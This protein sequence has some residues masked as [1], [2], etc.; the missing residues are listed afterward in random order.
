MCLTGHFVNRKFEF[1]STI[2]S[3]SWFHRRHFAI[4][5]A[6]AV[7]EKLMEL[8]IYE[9]AIAITTDGAANMTKMFESLRP[10]TRRI[11]C[12]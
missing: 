9:K 12:E 4:N 10:E 11:H 1:L 7:Q 6:Q 5:V 8:N 2:L 3:F